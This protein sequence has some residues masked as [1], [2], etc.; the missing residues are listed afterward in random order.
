MPESQVV[1]SHATGGFSSRRKLY[2]FELNGNPR[3]SPA[4]KKNL[5]IELNHIL[6][7]G[8]WKISRSLVNDRELE[9]C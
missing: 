8:S 2:G 3:K 1:L 5:E 4:S 9:I 6:C 7:S